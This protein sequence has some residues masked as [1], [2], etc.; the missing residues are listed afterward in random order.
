MQVQ[1][2]STVAE[3]LRREGFEARNLGQVGITIWESGVGYF[4]PAE[5]LS[6]LPSQAGPLDILTLVKRRA[7]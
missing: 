6:Q 2:L 7:A 3:R 4:L 5:E 1:D